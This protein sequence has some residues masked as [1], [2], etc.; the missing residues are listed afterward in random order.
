MPR[1][2][3]KCEK[4]RKE[5]SKF[6]RNAQERQ[7]SRPPFL[8]LREKVLYNGRNGKGWQNCKGCEDGFLVLKKFHWLLSAGLVA[9][10]TKSPLFR[11]VVAGKE[12]LLVRVSGRFGVGGIIVGVTSG[13]RVFL[14]KLYGQRLR[15]VLSCWIFLGVGWIG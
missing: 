7:E 5:E 1:P 11:L 2:F 8:P 15:L 12:V 6:V 3:S 10:F 9:E 14:C 13:E 4:G